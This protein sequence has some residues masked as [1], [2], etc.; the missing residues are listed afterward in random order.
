ME[1]QNFDFE[2]FVGLLCFVLVFQMW[3]LETSV[4]TEFSF[5]LHLFA[6]ELLD[7]QCDTVLYFGICI[8]RCLSDSSLSTC[9]I[10]LFHSST[11]LIVLSAR[12]AHPVCVVVD[13]KMS[14]KIEPVLP[15]SCLKK[16]CL[17]DSSLQMSLHNSVESSADRGYL[18]YGPHLLTHNT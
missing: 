4:V 8:L 1:K 10:Q 12:P 2:N 6:L 13:I 9:E 15:P 11:G 7:I 17:N 14:S 18:F 3:Y 5:Q 16:L